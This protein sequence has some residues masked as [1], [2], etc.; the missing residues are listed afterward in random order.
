MDITRRATC[1]C[2]SQPSV[3]AQRAHVGR[4][5]SQP[6]LSSLTHASHG[7]K[8]RFLKTTIEQEN[9]CK[10]FTTIAKLF[11]G[12]SK[13]S[14]GSANKVSVVGMD[15]IGIATAYSLITQNVTDNICLIDLD[16][17]VL[18][19]EHMDLEFGALFHNNP[20]IVS[21]KDPA[22]TADSK[23]CIVISGTYRGKDE[24]PLVYVGRNVGII[25]ALIP[26]LVKYSPNTIIIIASEPV[27][28]LSYASWKLSGF[29]KNR[30]IGIGTLLDTAR[31]R[32]LLSLRMG[33]SPVDCH[34]YIIGEH[35]ESSIPVWSGVNIGGV[36]LKNINPSIG[37]DKDAE[38]WQE[39]HK[40]VVKC[41]ETMRSLKGYSSWS[42][43]IALANLC[44][45]IFS[46]SN[47]IFPVSTYVRGEHSIRDEVFLSLP[48]VIGATGVTDIV[49]QSLT[50][51]EVTLLHTSAERVANLQEP[52]GNNLLS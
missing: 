32:Y 20:K 21:S 8:N 48:C 51:G 13:K 33:I 1:V 28:I 31:F 47:R 17:D 19:G 45:A 5:R 22:A 6:A 4:G 50:E 34:G 3:S 24:H 11:N 38:N 26:P 49:R 39:L 30:I 44:K 23:I 18:K 14:Y 12:V 41:D 52:A 29:P 37:S 40:E 2:A 16:E 25:K 42:Q 7:S 46:N 35:G 27:D 10:Q 15:E 43:A 9:P 36:S